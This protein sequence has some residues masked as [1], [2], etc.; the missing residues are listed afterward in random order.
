MATTFY[1]I[2]LLNRY[3]TAADGKEG[4][5]PYV[6]CAPQ[7]TA[8]TDDIHVGARST[9]LT[10]GTANQR[11]TGGTLRRDQNKHGGG[12]GGNEQSSTVAS[13]NYAANNS[14]IRSS[15][16]S[17]QNQIQIHNNR[18]Y[19]NNYPKPALPPPPHNTSTASAPSGG[20]LN[21]SNV[22]AIPAVKN[23]SMNHTYTQVQS[24]KH[25]ASN[26]FTRGV[27]YNSSMSSNRNNSSRNNSYRHSD[28]EDYLDMDRRSRYARFQNHKYENVN[29]RNGL[30]GQGH[31]RHSSEDRTYGQHRQHQVQHTRY[32]SLDRSGYG[33]YNREYR[34]L[35]N[36]G[37]NQGRQRNASND[38]Y[39][40][41][42][43]QRSHSRDSHNNNMQTFQSQGRPNNSGAG[44]GHI[45]QPA[46][47]VNVSNHSN[48][49]RITN[50][51]GPGHH[52][53]SNN[54]YNHTTA[55]GQGPSQGQTLHQGH[56]RGGQQELDSV[57]SWGDQD[58]SSASDTPLDTSE[59]SSFIKRPQGRYIVLF[60]FTG[61][62]CSHYTDFQV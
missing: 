23:A 36:V 18:P 31:V 44:Q 30:R 21:R 19:Y 12:G 26:S 62:V 8:I 29:V 11:L 54:T 28:N 10:S 56:N 15:P 46:Q 61:Q 34:P 16:N 7:G 17:Q 41:R 14:S 43:R 4:F 32:H 6:Y 48:N 51:R 35:H 59:V 27:E 37:K 9:Y 33:G 13:K 45:V 39:V 22:S 49:S 38:T 5:V 1:P 2:S 55:R 40:Q 3:V 42:G 53:S 47:S 50:T 52:V 57:G 20:N 58:R 60:P 25:N 24:N